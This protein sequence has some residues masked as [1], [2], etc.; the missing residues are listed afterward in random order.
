MQ[1]RIH[2]DIFD[3]SSNNDDLNDI[4][5]FFRKNRHQLILD[6]YDDIE[7]FKMSSWQKELNPRDLK[8]INEFIRASARRDKRDHLIALSHKNEIDYFNPKEAYL[9]LNQPLIILVE[10]AEFEPPFINAII[11][12]FDDS[13]ILINAKN[14][15]WMKYSMDAGSSVKQVIQGDIDNHF[16]NAVFSKSKNK[17]LR[18]F[19]IIDSDKEFPEMIVNSVVAKEE[20][21]QTIEVKYHVLYKREKENYMPFDILEDLNYDYFKLYKEL[22]SNEQKDFFDVEEGFKNKNKS[23]KNWKA[24]VKKMF[25]FNNISEKNWKVLKEGTS[26]MKEFEKGKFKADFSK[27]FVN[28]NK[29]NMLERITHQPKYLNNRNEFEHI[30]NE[31]KKLL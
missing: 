25:D 31:I 28:A 12:N 19:V 27:L 26:K 6:D 22:T 15:Q 21:L 3:D 30:V 10:N 1:I 4:L 17:Y 13:G 16:E 20:Y 24:E 29:K 2:K 14:E 18:Y 11:N 7:A 23:D 9:F 8:V 5:S